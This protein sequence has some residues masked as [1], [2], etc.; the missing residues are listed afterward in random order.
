MPPMNLVLDGLSEIFHR[1]RPSIS[2]HHRPRRPAGTRTAVRRRYSNNPIGAGMA[3]STSLYVFEPGALKSSLSEQDF[4]NG[5][6]QNWLGVNSGR[7]SPTGLGRTSST[8]PHRRTP[9]TSARS[10][11]G[12]NQ[13]SRSGSR[14]RHQSPGVDENHNQASHRGSPNTLSPRLSITSHKQPPVSLK[15][16]EVIEVLSAGTSMN[17]QQTIFLGF[18]RS[19]NGSPDEFSYNGFKREDL[20]LDMALAECNTIRSKEGLTQALLLRC[21]DHKPMYSFLHYAI[22]KNGPH[23][24]NV[25]SSPSK[26]IPAHLSQSNTIVGQLRTSNSR[27]EYGSYEE[28]FAIQKT[29]T[30]STDQRL[31]SNRHSGYIVTCFKLLEEN[32]RQQSL[33]KSWLSWTGARE[34]YKYSPRTWNLRRITLHRHAITSGPVRTF[35]YV[36]ICEFGNILHPSNALQALD[37]CERLRARNCGHIALYQV[38]HSYGP[39]MPF[40]PSTLPHHSTN[41]G[42]YSHS[43]NSPSTSTPTTTVSHSQQT[44]QQQSSPWSSP[45]LLAS[46]ASAAALRR[47]QMLGNRGY[48]QDVDSVTETTARRMALM[49]MRDRS[50]GY[51]VEESTFL[52]S[53]LR[54]SSA[55][56]SAASVNMSGTPPMRLSG[57]PSP[58]V[59]S[60]NLTPPSRFPSYA[61]HYQQEL[62]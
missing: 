37:M 17:A 60:M 57:T 58:T 38:Q 21:M 45:K 30:S 18:V 12:T 13:T 5:P 48:S 62:V 22:F 1:Q 49:R 40:S 16:E 3:S 26:Q 39:T 46:A 27:S 14:G 34:I 42:Q 7:R 43:L 29:A 11:S 6:S 54:R 36:L 50:L 41:R 25:S 33:E 51:D 47:R 56:N 24:I 20:S 35:A 2:N 55:A 31:S 52:S 8:S 59:S 4:L 44:Q 23:S 15:S 9:V 19:T 28:L 32:Y 61:H 53:P 10:R